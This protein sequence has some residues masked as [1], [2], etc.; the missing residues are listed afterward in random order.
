LRTAIVEV[1]DVA[2][3]FRWSQ[4]LHRRLRK[5]SRLRTRITALAGI[6]FT[7]EAGQVL[8]IVGPNGAGKT[9]LLRI[10]ADL[11]QADSGSVRICGEDTAGN[12]HH[13]RRRIGYVSGD[14]RGFF[15]RLTG[16]QNLR[17]FCRLYGMHA[18]AARSR[19]AEMLEAFGVARH[20]E[21]L[22]RDYSAG[23]RRKFA[24]IR[25]MLHQPDVLVLDEV[26]NNLDPPSA[27]CVVSVVRQ[28]THAG[29]GRAAIW[30]THRLEEIGL[31]CDRVLAL[32]NGRMEFLGPAAGFKSTTT[33]PPQRLFTMIYRHTACNRRSGIRAGPP[34]SFSEIISK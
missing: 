3:Y 9:T 1:A 31:V 12:N 11:L 23:T 28:Y 20:A 30:S 22:F 32:N 25:A 10:V 18:A 17:F 13:V 6:T 19:I 26:T 24:L 7:A 34:S 4:P 27:D 21:Q 5:G 14:E 2:K 29:P 16:R 8:G 15:W 33:S